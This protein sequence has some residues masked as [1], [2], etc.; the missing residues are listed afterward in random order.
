MK[1][2][3]IGELMLRLSPPNYEKIVTTHNFIVNYG[4]AEA[5]VAVSL[6]N[7]GVD[8]TFFTVLPNTDLGKSCINYLKANDVHTKH[9]IK[10]DGRMGLYYLEEGVSVRPS[11][12]IYDRGSSAFAEYDYKDVDFENI[13]KDYDWLHLSGIT[14]ALSYNCRRLIDKAIKAAKKYGTIVSYDLNYRPSMWSAIGG[15]EKAQEVNKEIA[16]YVDVMIGNEEDFTA[17]LGFE[18]E[19]NDKDLKQLNLDG[20]KKMINEAAKTYPNFKAVATTLREVK[21]ATVNDWSAICWADGEIHKA[22]D[23]KG[24]EIMD[25]V[26][27]GDSFASGLIYGLMTTEDAELAVNYGA[28]HGALAMTTPGDTTMASKKEVEAIMGGAGARVQR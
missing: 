13:L 16:K 27:G 3:A 19:G 21:T 22:K 12:V 14:P 5:N 1:F 15:Q 18:I 28:A 25:R 2:I 11:Q 17:C 23:Y 26:G 8:S 24:L 20:Y 6:A 4:G 10:A 7:L 9:I